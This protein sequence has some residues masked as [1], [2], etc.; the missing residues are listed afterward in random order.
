MF[1]FTC[2]VDLAELVLNNTSVLAL[3]VD[4]NTDYAEEINTG[5]GFYLGIAKDYTITGILT[6]ISGTYEKFYM[7][8]DGGFN[9]EGEISLNTVPTGDTSLVPSSLS[10]EGAS[11][12][13]LDLEIQGFVLSISPRVNEYL[14][15]NAAVGYYNGSGTLDYNNSISVDSISINEEWSD[16]FDLT[17]EDSIGYKLGASLNYELSDNLNLITTAKYRFLEMDIKALRTNGEY[18]IDDCI[19]G[20]PDTVDLPEEEDFSGFEATIGLAYS[21]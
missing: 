10:F 14:T 17:L 18:N 8:S 7:S 19:L 20:I 13:N 21:F 16:S 9:M 6:Q 11:T 12:S 15:L 4:Y 5:N 3:D 1:R 2:A